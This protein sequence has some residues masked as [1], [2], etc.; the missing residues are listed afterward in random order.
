VGAL[1]AAGVAR[2]VLGIQHPLKHL[3]GVAAGALQASGVQVQLLGQGRAAAEGAAL[4]AALQA[5]LQVNEVRVPPPSVRRHRL[6]A[7]CVL[8][9]E[10]ELPHINLGEAST[11][12]F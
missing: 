10:R 7:V 9:Y 11:D 4:Q 2:V 5:C 6:G 1:L 12:L 8:T 3:R